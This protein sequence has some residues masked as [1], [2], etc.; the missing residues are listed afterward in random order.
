MILNCV[1]CGKEMEAQKSTKKYCSRSCENKARA[2]RDAM[3]IDKPRNQN[4]MLEKK[5]SICGKSF[6]P[7][8]PSANQR[9]CCYDCA[10]DGKQLSRSDFL[11]VIRKNKGGRCQRCG[12]DTYLGALDFHH[13]DPNEKEF[14][15]GDRDFRL[16]QCIEEIEKC[17]M[18]CTNCHRELHAGLWDI[19]DLVEREEVE[20]ETH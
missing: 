19:K 16:E 9:K 13:I 7:K 8:T 14:T 18:I 15:V 1:I 5:C 4:G 10:P 20:L 3:N 17:I 6:Y 2:I 11:N 12:Y